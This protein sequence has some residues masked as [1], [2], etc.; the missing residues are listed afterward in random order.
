MNFE[1]LDITSIQ[2]VFTTAAT[3]IASTST[4]KAPIMFTDHHDQVNYEMGQPKK[5]NYTKQNKS[6]PDF[7]SE[8]GL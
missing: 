2:C 3:S 1:I 8:E 7:W 4:T 6:S 5:E